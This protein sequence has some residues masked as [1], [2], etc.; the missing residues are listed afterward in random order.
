MSVNKLLTLSLHTVTCGHHALLFFFAAFL[1]LESVRMASFN[2]VCMCSYS[3]LIF[4]SFV[5]LF[6]LALY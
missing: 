1:M 2:Y 4:V 3:V 5:L 6:P